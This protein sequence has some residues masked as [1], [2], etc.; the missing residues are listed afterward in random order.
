MFVPLLQLEHLSTKGKLSAAAVQ[1][2]KLKSWDLRL[3]FLRKIQV[4][5]SLPGIRFA[6]VHYDGLEKKTPQSIIQ[7][8]C[9]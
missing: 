3:K 7:I 8:I 6:T 2:L 9:E 1:T 5:A 4:E